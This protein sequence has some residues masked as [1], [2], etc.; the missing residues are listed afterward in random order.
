MRAMAG[1]TPRMPPGPG[2][3]RKGEEEGKENVMENVMEDV[4]ED[5]KTKE[6]RGGGGEE[7][8]TGKTDK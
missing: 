2:G 6:R 3:A 4:M 7:R 1:R 5:V 8:K